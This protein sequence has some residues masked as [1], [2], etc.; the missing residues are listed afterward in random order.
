MPG[1]ARSLSPRPPTRAANSRVS[2]QRHCKTPEL[3]VLYR[4][5]TELCVRETYVARGAKVID[6]RKR[7]IDRLGT[8]LAPRLLGDGYLIVKTADVDSVEE[9]RAAA[10][11]V[12]RR[13]GTKIRTGF[14]RSSARLWAAVDDDV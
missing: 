8:V 4:I 1:H 5:F 13:D 14:S 11:A 7:R 10:R 9:W 6:L 3:A 12:G 2:C